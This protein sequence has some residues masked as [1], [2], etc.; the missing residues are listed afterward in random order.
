MDADWR[1]AG[2]L[3]AP[4]WQCARLADGA[5]LPNGVGVYC[6]YEHDADE[7]VYIGEASALLARS[8]TH[9]AGS[10][11]LSEPWLAVLPLADGTPKYVLHELEGD[12]LGW[13][14][15]RTGRAPVFQYRK[16][17]GAGDNAA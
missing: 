8:A 15:W 17:P 4:W 10:W 3:Q 13:H 5:N 6:I 7:P 14:F 16:A 9:A 11:S 12:L 2:V 1:G